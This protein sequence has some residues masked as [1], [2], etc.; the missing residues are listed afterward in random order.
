MCQERLEHRL[1]KETGTL[2][3]WSRGRGRGRCDQRKGG[4]GLRRRLL[5]GY[6]LGFIYVMTLV[7]AD[8]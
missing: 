4:S 6:Q 3:C 2:D 5:G 7:G 8:P 1:E